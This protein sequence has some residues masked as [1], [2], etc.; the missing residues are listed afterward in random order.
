MS[1]RTASRSAG[2]LSILLL[3][4]QP[5]IFFR[6][7]LINPDFHIPYDIE[8]FHLPLIAYLAQCL[9]RGVAPFWDP[10]SF[11]GT[12]FHAD[13]QAQVF[14]PF[15]VL[16]AICGNIHGG[17]GLFYCVEALVPIHMILAGI[18]SFVLLRRMGLNQP[19]SLMGASIYQLGGFFAS[20]AQHLGAVCTGAWLPLAALALFELRDGWRPRWV[21][22]LAIAVGMGILSGF[23][24]TM[25]V[26]GAAVALLA[27]GWLVTREARWPLILGLGAGFLG[28]AALAAVELIPLWTLM[29]S[30]VASSRPQAETAGG[31]LPIEVLASLV[32]PDHY[33][34]FEPGS[35]YKLPYNFTFLYAYCGIATV[36]LILLAP[37]VRRRR[38]IL[39]LTL[40]VLSG[41]W[42]LGEHTPVYRVVF[43]HLPDLVRGGLYSEEALMAFTFFAAITAAIVLN[44]LDRRVPLVLL[45]CVALFTSWDLMHAG[46]DRPMNTA[47]GGAREDNSWYRATGQSVGEK[48]RALD[49]FTKPPSRADYIDRSF[50]QGILGPAMLGVPTTAG[51][52]PFELSRVLNVRW[53]Y[54]NANPWERNLVVNRLGSPLLNMLNVSL[55]AGSTAIPPDQLNKAGLSFAETVDGISIYTNPRSLPRFFLVPHVRRSH[56]EAETLGLLSRPSFDPSSEAIVEGV[57]ND[58]SG[59]A[60]APVHVVSYDS[61]RLELSVTIDRPAFLVT[62]EAMYPGWEATVNGISQPLLM[63]NGAFRGLALAGGTSQ[64]AM[65]YHPQDFAIGVWISLLACI[66]VIGGLVSDWSPRH[67]TAKIGGHIH[68]VGEALRE[69]LEKSLAAAVGHR[70]WIE[71][72]GALFLVIA[73]FYWRIVFTGQ[74]SILTGIDAINRS[75]ARIQFAVYSIRHGIQPLWDS[76]TLGGHGPAW[77][78]GAFYPLHLIL[79]LAPLGRDG[80][81]APHLYQL[82]F[83]FVHFLGACFLFVLARQLRLDRFPAFVAALCFSLGG[84]AGSTSNLL[85]LESAIWLPLMLFFLLRALR[86]ADYRDARWNAALSGLALGLSLLAGSGA[87]VIMQVLVMVTAG[88]IAARSRT[89]P[90]ALIGAAIAIGLAAGAL[91]WL[92]ALGSGANVFDPIRIRFAPAGI[93]RILIPGQFGPPASGDAFVTPYIGFFALLLALVAIF[94]NWRNVW[95]RYLAWTGLAGLLLSLVRIS[96]GGVNQ[97]SGQYAAGF[98]GCLLAGFGIQA[99]LYDSHLSYGVLRYVAKCLVTRPAQ[100]LMLVLILGDLYLASPATKS[101]KADYLAPLLTFRGAAQFLSKQPQISRVQILSNVPLNYGDVFHVETIPGDV[102]RTDLWNAGFRAL[103]A[104]IRQP[105]ALYQDA[106]WNVYEIPALPRAWTVHDTIREF[107]RAGQVARLA[108]PGFDVSKTAVVDGDVK[109]EPAVAG[110]PDGISFLKSQGN[111]VEVETYMNSRGLL[112]VSER[113]APGWHASVNG[114]S[115]PIVRVDGELRGVVLERGQN[116]ISFDY[117]PWPL[118]FAW[119]LTLA[120]FLFPFAYRRMRQAD[121]RPETVHS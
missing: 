37:F 89:R 46:A 95:V 34:I 98:A 73:V 120:A 50:S 56:D 2:V 77:G 78:N 1:S 68:A 96:I 100:L 70:T 23:A 114:A 55:L 10:W 9:R 74:S 112:I 51:D 83:V 13:L 60:T 105:G 38:A 67:T 111:H 43:Q 61:N 94:E 8:G 90:A 113:F 58:L 25:M 28:G 99:L 101:Q 116:E 14:Y 117:A 49:R 7:V 5:L 20:Q 115:V 22:A 81:L 66:T 109:L 52:N 11:T 19:A 15:A 118:Y 48:L 110:Q 108:A 59:L 91:E 44:R 71:S 36:A 27:I 75:Y 4:L 53:L 80:L 121:R 26:F 92:P 21:A 47:R 82:W 45:W 31:G 42:M 104:F 119:V 6:N 57:P 18:F 12:P 62:S 87:I 41:C 16:A 30:S 88:W 24:A 35:L 79:A 93:L 107:T 33:H 3:I 84:F 32:S 106:F 86:A 69:F 17:P 103:P 29:H 65:E 39:F 102:N 76:F 97:A 63:T 72:S 54:A 64:I 40:T 85:S